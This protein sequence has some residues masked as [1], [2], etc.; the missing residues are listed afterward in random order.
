MKAMTAAQKRNYNDAVRVLV[1]L[2]MVDSQSLRGSGGLRA[3][4]SLGTLNAQTR[5]DANETMFFS[6]QL[7]HIKIEIVEDEF[8]AYKAKELI[9]QEPGV[10]PG[11]QSFTWRQFSRVGVAAMVAN[12]GQDLNRVDM[13][14]TENTSAIRTIADAYGYT[15][16]DIRAAMLAG[17]PLQ[18]KKGQ[19]AREA[20]ERFADQIF[21]IGDSNRGVPGLLKNSA[22]PIVTAGITGTWS[23]ATPAQML[24]DLYALG[25]AVWN[26][27]LQIHSPK[28]LVLSG[29]QFQVIAST[30]FSATIPDTVLEVFLKSSTMI[31]E[32]VPW[33]RC[34]KAAANGTNNRALVYTRDPKLLAYIE[35]LPF[36][37]QPP[38]ARNLEF[39]VPCEGRVGGT[40]IYR[41]FSMAYC[42][43]LG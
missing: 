1:D 27:S 20:Y 42:D 7:E 43:I 21:A 30:P 12:Y 23:G 16:A 9:P 36:Q 14:G 13:F 2:G 33:L 4:Q 17:V 32:V 39:V 40:V 38:Q 22:V 29:A 6:R 19:M 31:S 5:M 18:A 11:A 8:P 10:N 28:T 34:D 24:A 3:A 15:T 25:F 26:Q 35:P 37:S 41:P